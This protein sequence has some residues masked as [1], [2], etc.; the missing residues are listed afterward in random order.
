PITLFRGALD[1][2]I[3]GVCSHSRMVA[4]GNLFIA[5]K[6]SVDDGAKYIE[7]AIS[8]GA[9][10]ILT[11]LP[12]PFLKGI[13]QLLHP[14][15]ERFEAALAA[16]FYH[17]PSQELFMVGVTGTNGKT[18]TTYLVKHLLDCLRSPCGL[19][20]TIEYLVG[21][22][23]F[24]ADRTTPDAITN[25]KLLREMV[26]QGCSAAAMEVSSHGLA[27]G[28]CAQIDFD[29]AVFT[30]LS[31]DH[32]DYHHTM[33]AYAGEKAKLF[34]SLG[35][36]KT[37][38][39]NNESSWKSAILAQCKAKVLSYG[40][41]P[42][43]SI[44]ADALELSPNRTTFTVHYQNESVNFAW[45]LIG[46]YNILNC[47]AAIGVCLTKGVALSALPLHV[48]SFLAVRGRLEKVENKRGLHMY[49]DYAHTPD[50]LEK[51]L[52]CLQELKQGRIITVFG[53]GGDRDKGKRP[54]M[55]KTSE[56]GSDFTIVTSDNPRSENPR[57]ICEEIA[58]G[59]STSR[60][61]IIVDRRQAI[62]QAIRMATEKDLILIA[63]KG[64]ETYQLFS[65]QTIP[66]DDRKISQE[67]ANR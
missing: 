22:Y 44:Y 59:F 20:G 35:P 5:K 62:E 17:N 27:Q 65:H 54:K 37:A 18:T 53:C 32:L 67:I 7:Q 45:D 30:N 48:E 9:G 25:Q 3:T 57:Q 60:F 34:T 36:D 8:A 55:G 28:R 19:I 1:G 61:T 6:G 43:C 63:G 23:R 56:E 33:E 2:D 52:N 13:V 38:I 41:T 15:P 31:Q 14:Y 11:D 51:V 50:A 64:H 47:L 10:A 29:A 4:P 49:V 66:F 42:D 46:R 58:A 40:F 26:K 12:N 21:S 24:E 39:V 16:R